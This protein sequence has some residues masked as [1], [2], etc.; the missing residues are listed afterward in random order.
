MSL[1]KTKI[2][3]D[4]D[5]VGFI[6]VM[7]AGWI[8]VIGARLLLENQ[9]SFLSGK[10]E[11]IGSWFAQGELRS[12]LIVIW[13]V[14]AFI[15]GAGFSSIIT[16][17]YGLTGGLIFTGLILLIASFPVSHGNFRFVSIAIPLTM[18]SQNAATSLTPINRT[19]HLTGPATD[20]GI[21]LFQGD[22][23]GAMFWIIRW[24]AFPIGAYIGYE[25]IEFVVHVKRL[26][27]SLSFIV[28]AVI[29]LLTGI[30]QK[31]TVDIPLK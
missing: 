1:N 15:M 7:M 28:P 5:V 19:T 24:I 22:F 4:I 14:V 11:E 25:F 26:D 23:K 2:L 9:N 31:L 29:I 8:N 13:I 6:L 17:K 10:A 12:H 21:N 20:I 3:T 27:P 18:G 16:K 30:I